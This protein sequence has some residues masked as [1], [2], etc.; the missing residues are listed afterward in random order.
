MSK[1]NPDD[2]LFL[3]NLVNAREMDIQA[4]FV[5]DILEDGRIKTPV[6]GEDARA[7]LIHLAVD[8][9]GTNQQ[10]DIVL[11]SWGLLH[12]YDTIPGVVERRAKYLTE[13]IFRPKKVQEKSTASSD[14]ER[15]LED[16]AKDL[17]KLEK[18]LY[19]QI[20]KK[21]DAISDKQ[22]FLQ[23][24]RQAYLRK[25][26]GYKGVMRV[27]L[28]MP[29]YPVQNPLPL[30]NLPMKKRSFIGREEILDALSDNY[31]DGERVQILAGMGGVGKTKIAL[32]YAY[33]YADSYGAIAWIDARNTQTMHGSCKSFLQKCYPD[34][35]LSEVEDVRR[36]FLTY[37][38]QSSNWLIVYDNADYI[39]EEN[40]RAKQM[41]RDLEG[42]IPVGNGHILITTRCRRNFLGA[43]IIPVRVFSPELALSYLE[44]QTGQK[45]DDDARLLAKKLGYLPL[46]LEYVSSYIRQ[47]TTYRGYLDLWQENGMELFDQ[48]DADYAEQTVR[49]AFQITLD[50]LNSDAPTEDTLALIKLLKLCAS[51]DA[52]YIPLDQYLEY[53]D[54][55]KT[56]QAEGIRA[57]IACPEKNCFYTPGF[58]GI[59]VKLRYL[60]VALDGSYKVE[61]LSGERKGEIEVWGGERLLD[62]ILRNPLKRD[63]LIERAAA[64][65]LV[66]WDKQRIRMHPL[67]RQIIS[68][69]GLKGHDISDDLFLGEIYERYGDFQ[70]AKEHKVRALTARLKNFEYFLRFGEQNDEGKAIMQEQIA[71][72]KEE[73]KKY[74][75]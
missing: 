37:F 18:K 56:R 30:N 31:A 24:A 62:K 35:P 14:T 32:Q 44:M 26:P 15:S 40:A 1:Q 50:K 7:F 55:Y 41:K 21:Y 74:D 29:S 51:W 65:S 16:R 70:R 49:Q 68:A 73:L 54:E 60:E 2:S 12:G 25:V 52:D 13:S 23:A 10:S 22:A 47:N 43:R 39:D 71:K 59:F 28:P 27:K 53:M 36:S 20:E 11:C 4:G 63:R 75:S 38:E 64:Y 19:A 9:F 33:H 34:Q 17:S 42:R 5:R 58:D 67:L 57:I 72:M 48:N 69:D 45:I 3:N 61:Y 66:D 46:A 8:T 6:S